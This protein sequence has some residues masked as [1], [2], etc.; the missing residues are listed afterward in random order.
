MMLH[1][2]WL[3]SEAEQTFCLAGAHGEDARRL[4]QPGAKLIW[5]I[6]ASSHYEAMCLYYE[7]MG[8]G[9]YTTDFPDLDKKTYKE[10][11]WE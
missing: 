7:Y 9:K 4:L 3:E 8:W 10:W 2:L 11:G 1:E 5:S 6:E